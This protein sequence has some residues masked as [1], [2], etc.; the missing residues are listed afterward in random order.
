ME[1]PEFEK[2]YPEL[3]KMRAG[4]QSKP[5]DEVFLK[6]KLMYTVNKICYFLEGE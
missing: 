2:K 5:Q 6:A 3:H 4:Q 1:D